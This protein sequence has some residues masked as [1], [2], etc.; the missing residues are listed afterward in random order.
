MGL[1]RTTILSTPSEG[2]IDHYFVASDWHTEA[3]H[4]P[5]WNILKQHA[6]LIKPKKKRKL[7]INGDFL[8]CLHLMLKPHEMRSAAK[9]IPRIEEFIELT[10]EEIAWGN[11]ILDEAQKIF[12]EI[13][14]VSGNHDYRYLLWMR[15]YCPPEYRHHFDIYTRLNL[16]KRKILFIPYPDYLDIGGIT[17]THGFKHGRN[18]NKQHIDIIMRSCLYGHVHHVNVTSYDC[19]GVLKRATSLPTMSTLAPE[20]QLKRGENNWTNGYGQIAMRSSG[21]YHLYIHEPVEDEL[22]LP[23]GTVLRG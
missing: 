1:D 10:D 13:I 20:F 3:L 16:K 14:F 8:E 2:I 11:N 18:H 22:V 15:D 17:V 21:K 4:L 9:K 12:S 6:L 23:N 7:I 19:R 5:T